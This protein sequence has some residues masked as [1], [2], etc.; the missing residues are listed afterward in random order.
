MVTGDA[1]MTWPN[2]SAW[3]WPT[4][5]WYGLR[6]KKL[7][8]W[9]EPEAHHGAVKLVGEVGGAQEEEINGGWASRYRTHRGRL[10]ASQLSWLGREERGGHDGAQGLLCDTLGGLNRQRRDMAG[11]RVLGTERERGREKRKGGGG[12]LLGFPVAAGVVL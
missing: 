7:R 4:R 11:A 2:G 3:W 5:R 6:W 10:G 1:P 9:G 12:G 8:T